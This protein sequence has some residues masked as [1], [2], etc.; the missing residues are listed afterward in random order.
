H[1]LPVEPTPDTLSMYITYESH[2][3]NAKSVKSYLSGIVNSLEGLYPDVRASRNAALVRNTLGG[4]LKMSSHVTQRKSPLTRSDVGR[5][6]ARYENGSHDDLLFLAI[7][8]TGFNGLNRLGELVWPDSTSLQDYRKVVNFT[9]LRR[10]PDFFS[11]FLPGHKGNRFFNGNT[12]LITRR[13]DEANALPTMGRYL[14]SRMTLPHTRVHTALFVREC[15]S[16][17]TRSWF[18]SY[19]AANFD[20]DIA[21]HSIR[22]GGATDLALRGV[23]DTLIQK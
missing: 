14:D 4:C 18:L 22:S 10:T 23:P 5:M 15:G 20:A 8:V 7:L 19:F 9:S 16:V 21:G 6:I 12:V 17:P 3:I 1:S 13:N 11:F 2:Y